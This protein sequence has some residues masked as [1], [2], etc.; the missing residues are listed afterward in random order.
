LKSTLRNLFSSEN[1]GEILA[2]LRG[3]G[4]RAH[5]IAPGWVRER[6]LMS[7]AAGE[8]RASWS[9][10]VEDAIWPG[11]DKAN[12]IVLAEDAA[13]EEKLIARIRGRPGLHKYGLF[14]HV[15]PSLLC[16]MNGMAAGQPVADIKRYALICVPRSGSRYLAAVFNNRGIGAPAEHIRE[17]LANVITEGKLGFAP[18][19]VAL[20]RF[21]QRNGIFGTKLISTF[22]IKASNRR[23]TELETNIEWMVE[24][25][26][27]II[28]LERPLDETVV[29]SYIAFLMRKWHFFGEL[30]EASRAKLDRL[31]FEDGAAW[32]EYLRFRAEQIVVDALS[33]SHGFPSI[34]Y[35]EIETG[36]EVVVERICRIIG[37]DQ[38]KLAA[39]S[40]RVPLATRSKSPTYERFAEQLEHLLDERC[41]E[42]RP[43]LVK[44]LRNLTSLGAKGVE[45]LLDDAF[46]CEAYSS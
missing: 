12:C 31:E 21:G 26:Y 28:R 43:R 6:V 11:G 27:R 45:K 22:L 2:F 1:A 44:K 41:N 39:G 16:G 46:A 30:D 4:P 37:V 9:E 10:G 17:P 33:A 40:A 19:V 35:S 24:R 18:A 5:I 13:T 32:E 34:R 8:T 7:D 14:R 36:I 42:L 23:M 38:E 29:S 3:R 20:E 25:G 15:F